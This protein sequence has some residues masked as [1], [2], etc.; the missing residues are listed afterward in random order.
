MGMVSKNEYIIHLRIQNPTSFQETDILTY[1]PN[2]P[3]EPKPYEAEPSQHYIVTSN[4]DNLIEKNTE[5]TDH[6]SSVFCWW[7]CQPFQGEIY[8]IPICKQDDNIHAIGYFCSPACAAAYNLEAGNKFGNNKWHHM[9]LLQKMYGKIQPA[10]PRECL[11]HFGGNW[12]LSQFRSNNTPVRTLYPPIYL[13]KPNYEH[14]TDYEK[15][16]KFVPIDP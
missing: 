5:S 16:N 7:D 14:C 3:N 12:P 4:E 15:T 6:P 11:I 9:E 8:R 1:T 2:L 10:P 13:I